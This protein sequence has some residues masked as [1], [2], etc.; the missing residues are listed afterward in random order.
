LIDF[1]SF[2][3]FQGNLMGYELYWANLI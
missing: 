3:A 1:G 2:E